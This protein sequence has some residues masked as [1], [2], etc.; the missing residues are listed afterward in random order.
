MLTAVSLEAETAGHSHT[1]TKTTVKR[2]YSDKIQDY[3]VG[4]M[5]GKGAF[6][7]VHRATSLHSSS[8][9]QQVAIKMVGLLLNWSSILT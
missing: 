7:S 2:V 1:S 6:G 8:F 9:N 3:K 4:D 5:I